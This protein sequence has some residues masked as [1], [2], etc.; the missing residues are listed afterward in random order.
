M[1]VDNMFDIGDTISDEGSSVAYMSR[2]HPRTSGHLSKLGS[3]LQTYLS[4]LRTILN[5]S[6]R[7]YKAKF[8]FDV[9][10]SFYIRFRRL[11]NRSNLDKA[12][13]T[14]GKAVEL[15]SDGH[16]SKP[17]RLSN[18]VHLQQTRFECFGDLSDL[19]NAISNKQKA[20]QLTDDGQPSKPA[21]LLDLGYYQQSR[22]EHLGDLS[23]LENAISNQKRALQLTGDYH[24]SKPACLSNLGA[25]Q[26]TR[27]EHLGEMSDLENAISN[28]QKA[29]QLTDDDHP[30]K[31]ARLSNLGTA[32]QTRFEQF[33][34]LSDLANA[35][36]NQQKAAR[37]AGDR[38]PRKA[39]Y[40]MNLGLSQQSRFNHL[41]DLSDLEN[42]IS[43]KY[44]AVQL[45]GDGHPSKPIC[46][47]NLA[48]AQQA[49][50]GR[51]G[52]LSDLEN[53]ISNQH[54][55]VE[56]TA[57]GHPS[58]PWRLA[59]LGAAQLQRF[60]YLG[61]LSD[62][63]DAISNTQKAV[64]L[65]DDRNLTKALHLM[66]LGISQQARFKHFGDLSD[67]E[68]AISNQQRAIQL[69]NDLHPFQSIF[70]SYLGISQYTRF[71]HL[72]ELSDLENAISNQ[73]KAVQLTDDG[74]PWKGVHLLVLGTSQNSRFQRLGDP[75]DL[76]ACVLSYTAAARLKATYPSY[77][78]QAACRWAQTSH[79]NGNLL[80]ALDGYHTALEL[81]P[82]VAWL[83]LD[84]PS[85]QEML[86]R[87]KIENLGCHA[88][89]C[90]IQLGRLEEAIELLDMGLS[91][92][93]QQASSLRSDLKMLREEDA[94]LAERFEKIGRQLDV[95]NF[96]NSHFTIQE[97][98]IRVDQRSAEEIG[99]ERR[100][101]VGEWEGP[102]ERIR[103]LPQFKNFLR[104][105]PFRQL[106]QAGTGGK[107]IIINAST[108]RMDA[109]IFGVT[110]P[111]EHVSLPNINFETLTEL[112]ENIVVNQS[113]NASE[114]QRRSYTKRFLKP[115]LRAIWNDILVPIFEKIHIP[116]DAT[117]TVLPQHRI[118]WYATGPLT[119]IPIH[120]AGPGGGVFDVGRLVISSYVT[121]LESLFR[122]Q[123]KDEP[124][125]KERWKLLSVS[126]PETPGQNSLLT[127]MEEVTEV[128][129]TFC[130]SGWSEGDIVCL[131][132]SEATVDAVS[133]ALNSCSWVHLA[134]HG[135]QDQTLG[136]KSAFVL[137]DGHLELGEIASKRLSNGQFA[138]LSAC[139][140]ASGKKDLPGE[141]MHLAAGIQFSGFSSVIATMWRIRDE[142]APKVAHYTYKYLFRNGIE[143]LNPSDAA[144]ALH[145]AILRLRDDPSVTI[146]PVRCF[147]CG[148]VIGDKWNA[149]LALLSEDTSEGDALD[150][151][152]LKRYCCRRMVL[153][154]VDL[155][156]KLLH[157]NP[158]ERTKDKQGVP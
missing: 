14:Q 92:S 85:R 99:R 136:M 127:T 107:V 19:H 117:T 28:K 125:P 35:I 84:T 47:S 87:G 53:A 104:A 146:I 17:E 156:E 30:S 151:L 56:L 118:W 88:A 16:P 141:A 39:V 26:Q 9:G 138:F 12:I 57:D 75:D 112:S 52:D 2:I 105:L 48:T 150:A 145:H 80:S 101:L 140:A 73:R 36:S 29:V 23:D 51:L 102:V 83:G 129:Q 77:A 78:L 59:D 4:N 97:H 124:V 155:I 132:G 116:L 22:F 94:E 8:L 72:G 157:Y 43:N 137:Y 111:I 95:G 81:F 74:H 18:L 21:Y 91:F 40:L 11:G 79:D 67:L 110:G 143:G 98:T 133:S 130:S 64:Q 128:V 106:R 41:G 89:A 25:A 148:K 20:I 122:A 62:L 154:H 120:A 152:E 126:Q 158:M 3:A 63:A 103:R 1:H 147:S 68:H 58:K 96:P 15:T 93:W 45:T 61:H 60:E 82:K 49:R 108:R 54:M 121:T 139:Q 153:T 7:S 144:T 142:D 50:F 134:C 44:K 33:G 100:L 27:F 86:L 6:V 123:Q 24:P 34:D 114:T 46:L 131:R 70:L 55:S 115:A 109:L 113:I 32:Q 65:T 135:F 149:Y 38:H 37:L 90:A 10:I 31:P 76:V 119:F 42:A 66:N 71:E 69:T 13:L 5:N